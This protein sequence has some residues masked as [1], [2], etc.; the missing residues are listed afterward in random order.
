MKFL[1]ILIYRKRQNMNMELNPI[2]IEAKT[3]TLGN[4]LSD[5]SYT[6]SFNNFEKMFHIMNNKISDESII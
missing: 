2:I 6:A 1:R 5:D 4:L 3:R